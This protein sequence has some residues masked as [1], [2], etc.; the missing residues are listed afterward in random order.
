MH[1]REFTEAETA[2]FKR[3]RTPAQIQD[4]IDATRI[5]FEPDGDTCRSPL[6]VVRTGRAHCI[7]GALLA[8][9]I[10]SLHGYPPLL[11]DLKSSRQDFDH[12]V[13]LFKKN[14]CWGAISKTN[15][16]VLRYREPVYKSVRELAMSYFHEYF[17]DEGEKTLQSFSKPF[18][19]RKFDKKHW[20]TDDDNLW[21]IAEALD[22]SPHEPIAPK[23]IL[24]NL[25]KADKVEI[26]AGKITEWKKKQ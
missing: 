25:R 8:A 19:L 23:N 9:Y 24:K 20:Q 13:A 22:A 5:N 26:V 15:H 4:Y 10:L 16:A 1:M 21:Y 2:V 7:E 17:T 12:V 3:L 18:N 11:L 6:A 14:E